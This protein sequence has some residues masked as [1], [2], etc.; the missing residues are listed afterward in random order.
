M[1]K[2]S[3]YTFRQNRLAATLGQARLRKLKVFGRIF[4]EIE[5]E[6]DVHISHKLIYLVFFL[7]W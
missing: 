6:L 7:S 4:E 3:V 2:L 1:D 5:A